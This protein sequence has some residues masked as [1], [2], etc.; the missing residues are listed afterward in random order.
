MKDTDKT[1]AQLIAELQQ[2][3][4]EM[5][6]MQEHYS[7][8]YMLK[9]M[10]TRSPISI[11]VLDGEGYSVLVNEAHTALF[12]AKPPPD[13]NMFSDSLLLEQELQNDF[14]MLKNGEAVFFKDTWYNAHYYNPALTDKMVWVK[15]C[16]F[17]V[18]IAKGKPERFV[19]MHEDI[20]IRKRLEK[21]LEEKN[22]LLENQNQILEEAREQERNEISL[23]IHD[24]LGQKLSA[25]KRKAD[26]LKE[27]LITP[28]LQAECDEISGLLHDTL[29]AVRNIAFNLW[30]RIIDHVGI[31]MAI[32]ALA[33]H[34]TNIL[35]IPFERNIDFTIALPPGEARQV[36]RIAQ[37]ALTNISRHSHADKVV[38]KFLRT[39]TGLKL[40]ISDTG[41]GISPQALT[42]INSHGL[43]GMRNRAQKLQGSLTLSNVKPRGTKILLT[44]PYKSSSQ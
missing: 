40:E 33:D 41:T 36:Y 19:I 1:K 32:D 2:L 11:Q 3:R 42:A 20:T 28:E 37:E 13:Y 44:F 31:A 25:I 35:C 15:T 10:I 22:V 38:L 9:E 4:K 12:E 30:P 8:S 23:E 24:E 29:N 27:K 17:P 39:T 18:L 6:F 26:N 16:A 14:K 43:T 34:F 21:E 5:E 7:D